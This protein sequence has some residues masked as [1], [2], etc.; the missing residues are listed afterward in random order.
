V[1]VLALRA[2]HCPSCG[3]SV[4]RHP[5]FVHER[6]R[7]ISCKSCG[8]QLEVVLGAWSYHLLKTVSLVF[9]QIAGV[10]LFVLA[11]LRQWFWLAI[12]ISITLLLEIGRATVARR[13][14]EIRW[15]NQGSMQRQR[16]GR[17]VPE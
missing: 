1:S 4:A 5:R 3:F 14:A 11:F 6:V 16:T 9:W 13:G 17:W 12:L 10:G 2:V 15:I 8:A 7:E